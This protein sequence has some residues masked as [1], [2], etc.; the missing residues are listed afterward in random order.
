MSET[1]QGWALWVVA[2]LVALATA[3]VGVLAYRSRPTGRVVAVAVE[4]SAIMHRESMARE[5]EAVDVALVEITE[6]RA[7]LAEV[8]DITD[9]NERSD[10]LSAMLNR[11]R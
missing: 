9:E 1:V 10:A 2:G 11:R 8:A 6:K 4:S 7:E 5:R 3:F